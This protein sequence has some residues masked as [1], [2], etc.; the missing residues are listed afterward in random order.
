MNALTERFPTIPQM[1]QNSM[2]N[3]LTSIMKNK[4]D[5]LEQELAEIKRI[6]RRDNDR[7]TERNDSR[8]QRRQA[9]NRQN[10]QYDQSQNFTAQGANQN[11]TA[12]GAYNYTAQGAQ[13]NNTAQ[14]AHRDFSSGKNYPQNFE[15]GPGCFPY[16]CHKCGVLGHRSFNCRGTKLTCN[17]CR[18]V[19]HIQAACPQKKAKN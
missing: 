12:Q 3:S 15:I 10:N 17:I 18:E 8:F 19:G 7:T 16:R 5:C 1:I 13:N 9:D 4:I 6:S 14:G 11:R 2:E